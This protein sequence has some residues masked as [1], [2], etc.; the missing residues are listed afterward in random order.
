MYNMLFTWHIPFSIIKDNIFILLY[1]LF[2][3]NPAE[4]Y[5]MKSVK[6]LFNNWKGSI[7]GAY[8]KLEYLGF[9]PHRI[10]N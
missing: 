9:Y 6:T 2:Q 10:H 8:I 4:R 7:Q 5:E 3:A 1:C